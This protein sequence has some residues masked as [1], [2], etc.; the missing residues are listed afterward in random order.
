LP[1]LDTKSSRTMEKS[2]VVTGVAG[3]VG[4]NLARHLL[5][6]GYSVVGIDNLSAAMLANV[7]ERAV[8]SRD[9]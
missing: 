4:S 2:V 9:G 3:F 1:R 8:S 6:W 5:D 7:D